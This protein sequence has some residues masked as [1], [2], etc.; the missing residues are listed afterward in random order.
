MQI[1]YVR[2]GGKLN[3]QFSHICT[4]KSRRFHLERLRNVLHLFVWL[5][6][7]RA[8]IVGS[9]T[10][11]RRVSKLSC[12]FSN[13]LGRVLSL[14]AQPI[15]STAQ[16]KLR[17]NP[18]MS[19]EIHICLLDVEN[20][21]SQARASSGYQKTFALAFL[22]ASASREWFCRRKILTISIFICR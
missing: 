6:T 3:K 9:L 21:L 15:K 17:S 1:A 14:F 20:V 11:C 19:R 16:N 12:T 5:I 2:V 4:S 18:A 8:E 13:L 7:R 10:I 22:L